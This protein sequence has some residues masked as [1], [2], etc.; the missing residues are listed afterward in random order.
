[1][2]HLLLDFG[3]VVIKT[4]FEMLHRVGSPP[5]FGPF[6][7]AADDVWRRMQDGELSERDYW[8]LRASE[9]YRDTNE[10]TRQLMA[11]VFA[12]PGDQVV[13]PETLALVRRIGGAAVLTNDL[14]AFHDDI[15]LAD[16]GLAGVFDPLVDLSHV[17]YLKP[18]PQSFSHALKSMGVTADEVVFV[19]D[20]P[21]NVAGAEAFGMAAVWFD[22]TDPAASIDRV[23]AVL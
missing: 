18:S 17:G 12:P 9:L 23:T 16:M 7:P 15:W 21:H 19:D 6:D 3:G 22:V 11:T 13:R 20:Q 5:W 14:A 1:M 4:P 8:R 2:R 10:P